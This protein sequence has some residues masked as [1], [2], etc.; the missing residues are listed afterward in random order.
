MQEIPQPSWGA[1]MQKKMYSVLL[2]IFTMFNTCYCSSEVTQIR[3]YDLQDRPSFASGNPLKGI[4]KFNFFTG[5]PAPNPITANKISALIETELKKFGQVQR[6]EMLVKTDQG[7]AVDLSSFAGGVA[8]IYQIQPVTA[9]NSKNLGFVRATLNVST[10]V[11]VQKTQTECESYIWSNNCFLSGNLETDLEN[12]ILQ[13]LQFLL[14][15]FDVDYKSANS[16]NPS[17]N[18]YPP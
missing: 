7:D 11:T 2:L 6:P 8:L 10:P 4:S 15:K 16:E 1:E 3:S 18:F 14:Q 5:F 17:F 13:S 12:L 9:L